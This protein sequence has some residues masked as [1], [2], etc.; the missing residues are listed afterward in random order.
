MRTCRLPHP[1]CLRAVLPTCACTATEAQ[2]NAAASEGLNPR[3]RCFPLHRKKGSLT[4]PS[5]TA[6]GGGR[7]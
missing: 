2:D 3:P 1:T 5:T 4:L 7:H 6:V